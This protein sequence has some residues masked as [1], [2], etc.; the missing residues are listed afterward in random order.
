MECGRFFTLAGACVRRDRRRTGPA[1]AAPAA[2]P[3]AGKE[4]DQQFLV[5]GSWFHG[6]HGLA[7]NK[8]DQLFAGSVIGQTHLPRA[9]RFG[10]G[11]PRH[12][13]ADG[14][15][16]RHRLRRGRHHGVDR[17]PAGQGLYPQAQRQDHRGRQRHGRSQFAGLRQGWPAVRLRG[18][19]RRRA[20]RDR[21]QERRQARLQAVPA[22]RAPPHRREDG[23]PERLRD[24]QGRR[25]PLRPAV[26]QGPDRQDQPRD[27]RD[28]SDRRGLQDPGRRQH[29]SAEPRQRLC[30]RH[31]HRRHMERQPHQ[32]GQEAGR[33][34]EARA[35]Q[36]RLRFAR[37]AVRHL[38]DRQRHLPRRQA[39]RR[40]QDHRRGQAR[41]S[42]RPR[43]RLRG[44]QGHGAR[45]RRLQL[46]HG[47][48]PDRRGA[49]RAPRAWRHPRL[50]D[51]HLGR[52]QA[53][54]ADELVLQ[55]RREGRPQDRQAGGELR[56]LRRS[57]RCAGD[58]RRHDLC[59][60]AGQ[61]QPRQGERRRQD[62]ARPWSRSCAGRWRWPRG[63][64][65]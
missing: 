2:A 39:D 10:R 29:R 4:Y 34:D 53:R 22:H 58:G 48:R 21:S 12:R 24:P 37:P 17:L 56:R 46:P 52:A 6:V 15:G 44:R 8:D 40:A 65:T 18:L 25:L 31:R 7:F 13:P 20:L 64:A 11:R 63:R 1:G 30:R 57:G 35:R 55:H 59:R 51:R 36:P 49:R 42:R 41:H 26:V 16:R 19:P 14:H 54:A 61:R 3:R 43:R 32:Q 33:L 5:P 23:R 28:R 62:S 50:S 9:G 47:R 45:R 60:R 38:D 27:R